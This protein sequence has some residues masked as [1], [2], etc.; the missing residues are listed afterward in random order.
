MA[1]DQS[2]SSLAT[3]HE[4]TS[5]QEQDNA[6]VRKLLGETPRKYARRIAKAK[7]KEYP[8][9]TPADW[10]KARYAESGMIEQIRASIREEVPRIRASDVSEADFINRF[11][12]ASKPVLISQLCDSWE[13]TSKWSLERLL[14]DYGGEKFKVGEDDDG[15]AVYVKLKYFIRYMLDNND[16]SP[17]YVFDSSFAERPATRALRQDYTL[18][19]FFTDDLFRLVGEK[20]RPPYRWFV[21]GPARSGSYVHIDPLGTSA[22]NALVRGHKCWAL[23]PPGVPKEVVQPANSGGREAIAWF[24]NVLPRLR[25]SEDEGWRPVT[26]IQRAG[27]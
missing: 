5:L 3:E 7:E 11:E 22:W 2:E 25:A 6:A 16:D 18:P 20:R 1:G 27:A 12:R 23:I 15:Y 13:A 10:N 17:L 24:A 9:R 8:R 4:M 19:K 14:A 26:A 21:L